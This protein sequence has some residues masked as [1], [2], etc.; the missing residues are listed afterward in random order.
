MSIF[1][2][3][4]VSFLSALG[5]ALVLLEILRTNRAKKEKYTCICFRE[6]LIY[7]EIP[8]IIVICRTLSEE[9]EII[10][11]ICEKESRRA[12]IKRL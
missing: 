1:G 9:D 5:I 3:I 10:K 4:F 11:R 8:D 2:S 12:L 7:D 6:E